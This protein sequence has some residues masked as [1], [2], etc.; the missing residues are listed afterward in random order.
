M[1]FQLEITLKK[2]DYLEFNRFHNLESTYGKMQIRKMLLIF[3]GV[4]ALLSVL[5]ILV[6]GWSDFSITYIVVLGIFIAIYLALYKK[7]VLQNLKS[8][9]KWMEKTGKLPFE[10]VTKLEFHEDRLIEICPSKRIEQE[11]A[12]LER[13]C[14]VE[15]RF[16]LLYTS[17]IGAHILPWS[18]I[19]AQLDQEALLAFLT[20][21]CST[22]E[23][24]PAEKL[25]FPTE[26]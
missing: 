9:I 17:S 25:P 10:P 2:E 4:I 18:Q 7:L 24:Y 1:V 22:V 6:N 15:G 16:I 14:I 5:I 11:Y 13:I 8:Q 20:S 3:L 19:N 12:L 23:R 21:K 26:L